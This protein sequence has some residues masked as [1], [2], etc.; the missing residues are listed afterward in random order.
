[1]ATLDYFYETFDSALHERNA[2]VFA[3]AGLSMPSGYVNWK[4]LL[5]GLA[6]DLG[7]NVEHEHDLL[8]LAQYYVN[9]QGGTRGR[10]NQLL[11][12]EFT[13]GATPTENHRLLAT[14]PIATYW[15][16]NYDTLIENSLA[17]AALTVDKKSRSTDLAGTRPGRDVTVFKMHG[18]VDDPQ[19][20]VLLKDDYEE[21]EKTHPLFLEALR[22][23]LVTKT[24]LFVGLSFDDPNIRFVLS[25]IRVLLGRNSRD[26]FYLTKCVAR[27]DYPEDGEGNEAFRYAQ[28]RQELQHADLS[29]YGIQV[30]LVNNYAEITTI[31]REVQRRYRLG[32]VFFSGAA[33]DFAPW[34]SRASS[35]SAEG[36]A[37]P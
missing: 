18:D 26:H 1:M 11:L 8:S 25:R 16:T 35:R 14:L 20:T 21:Y 36:S 37:G 28:I 3:G 12:N 27:G 2:A 15:T 33:A 29:R 13:R 5:R 17:A 7:L 23:D 32:S 19:G 22:G 24:F 4:A 30:V 6:R 10:V 31:L 34:A 9:A